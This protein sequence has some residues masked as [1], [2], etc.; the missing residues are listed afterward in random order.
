MF[1]FPAT[2]AGYVINS[3][4]ELFPPAWRQPASESRS[5]FC[6]GRGPSVCLV[7]WPDQRDDG[8]L[9]PM[10]GGVPVFRDVR[11]LQQPRPALPRPPRGQGGLHPAR[12]R[13]RRASIPQ[14]R[15]EFRASRKG[16]APDSCDR[17]GA[18][19]DRL[20]RCGGCKVTRYCGAECARGLRGQGTRKLA[21]SGRDVS[22]IEHTPR[23]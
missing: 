20:R 4:T 6:E 12:G 18:E 3:L 10:G 14:V 16:I 21:D 7:F 11:A 17:C 5:G 22:T 13:W 2:D 8:E 9:P 23:A 15:R 19:G 1:G